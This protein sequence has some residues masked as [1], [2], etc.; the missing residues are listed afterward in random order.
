MLQQAANLVHAAVG[1]SSTDVERYQ[2]HDLASEDE[3]HA[4]VYINLIAKFGTKYGFELAIAD[5][6]TGVG[7]ATKMLFEHCGAKPH[8]PKYMA[9]LRLHKLLL[10]TFRM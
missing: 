8:I 9:L 7:V 2:L 4:E 5:G 10:R 1:I 3:W 6:F